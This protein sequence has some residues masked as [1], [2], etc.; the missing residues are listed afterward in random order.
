MSVAAAVRLC[1]I[2]GCTRK[3]KAGGFCGTHYATWKK[4]GDPL[5]V[6]PQRRCSVEGCDRKHFAYGFCNMH[7]QRATKHGDP[8]VCLKPWETV[9]TLSPDELKRRIS[10]GKRRYYQR[11]R[12]D[13]LAY[14]QR[15]RQES[16]DRNRIYQR[17]H[18]REKPDLY[19]S[20]ARN[21]K[22]R[23]RQAFVE[24]V[25]QRTVY[26]RDGWVCGICRGHVDPADASIDHIVPISRGGKHSY[27]NVQTAHLSCNRQKSNKLPREC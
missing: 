21:R 7:R 19:K 9:E 23:L 3:Y 26:E 22:M 10:E 2:E 8:H 27:A 20:H 24:P 14:A 18:Y 15:R 5:H 16:P 12:S 1:R 6:R 17:K 13:L 25:D 11:R 4:Y